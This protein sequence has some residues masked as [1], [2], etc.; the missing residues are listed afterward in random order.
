MFKENE[1]SIFSK[2]AIYLLVLIAACSALLNLYRGV[3]PSPSFFAMTV[4][5]FILFI[6]AKVS[7]ISNGIKFSFGTSHMSANMANVYR[8]GYWLMV[9]GILCTFM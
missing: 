2:G 6:L 5:G 4:L 1:L 9:V 8:L 7:V 3:V